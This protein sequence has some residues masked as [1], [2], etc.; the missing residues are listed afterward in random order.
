MRKL[1]KK[2]MQPYFKR[3]L[4]LL[5]RVFFQ[6]TL[7]LIFICLKVKRIKIIKITRFTV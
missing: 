6:S 7:I 1:I 4:I 2:P 5:K 3:I